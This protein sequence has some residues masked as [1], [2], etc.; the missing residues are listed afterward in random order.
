MRTPQQQCGSHGDSVSV[1]PGTAVL[2]LPLLVYTRLS[3][4]PKSSPGAQHQRWSSAYLMIGDIECLHMLV[5]CPHVLLRSVVQLI[6][7]QLSS[8]VP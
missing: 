1:V 6:H 5:G 4:V 3:T 7:P 2:L 8:A